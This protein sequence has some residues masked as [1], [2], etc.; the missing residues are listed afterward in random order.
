MD[1]HGL[2]S[3]GRTIMGQGEMIYA[4]RCANHPFAFVLR[5]HSP[6]VQGALLES[7]TMMEVS[8]DC[9][10]DSPERIEGFHKERI[11]IKITLYGTSHG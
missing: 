4:V 10:D 7:V 9:R 1:R 6:D 11:N 5:S 2:I 8:K 3:D